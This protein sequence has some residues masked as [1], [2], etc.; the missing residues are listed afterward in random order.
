MQFI[1]MILNLSLFIQLIKL[2]LFANEYK[3]NFYVVFH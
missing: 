2:W 1:F 3:N